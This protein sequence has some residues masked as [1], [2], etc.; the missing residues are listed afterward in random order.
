MSTPAKYLAEAEAFRAKH[1]LHPA[2]PAEEISELLGLAELG[3]LPVICPACATKHGE[4]E[5][6]G[7]QCE[8]SCRKERHD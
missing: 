8:C 7:H 6:W 1:G 5:C 4:M 2:I 3:L